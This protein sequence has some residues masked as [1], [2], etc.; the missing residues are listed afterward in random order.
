VSARE[1][2]INLPGNPNLISGVTL[3]LPEDEWGQN[4]GKWVIN[5]SKHELTAPS[6]SGQ[7]AQGASSGYKTELV[8]KKQR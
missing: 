4:A 8:L 1:L 5:T 7:G 2:R 6:G 3:E